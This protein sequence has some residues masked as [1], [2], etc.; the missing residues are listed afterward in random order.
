MPSAP[1]PRRPA[2]PR[3]VLDDGPP[4]GVHLLTPLFG[5]VPEEV[6]NR[7]A[8]SPVSWTVV[9]TRCNRTSLG[10]GR[11]TAFAKTTCS[12]GL[13]DMPRHECRPHHLARVPNGWCCLRCNL[14]VTSARRAAA[15]AARCPV[16]ELVSGAG[17]DLLAARPWLSR[18][19]RLAH[20]WRLF[21]QRGAPLAAPAPSPPPSSEAVAVAAGALGA[22]VGG[23]RLQWT[24]HWVLAG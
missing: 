23:L 16:P 6:A 11:W 20:E 12:A 21:V 5:P 15:A 4:P 24:P 17:L 1:P 13:V 19:V 3:I 14:C 8:A 10:T 2:V 9:C 18:A 7:P 22:V